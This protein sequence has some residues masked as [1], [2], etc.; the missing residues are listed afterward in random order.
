MPEVPD[1]RLDSTVASP[2]RCHASSGVCAPPH[3]QE[4]RIATRQASTRSRSSAGRTL[5]LHQRLP[6]FKVRPMVPRAARALV[7]NLRLASGEHP[8]PVRAA[9]RRPSWLPLR[10]HC[11][12]ARRSGQVT[13]VGAKQ[14]P[15]RSDCFRRKAEAGAGHQA[16]ADAPADQSYARR[17]CLCKR[18]FL[19]PARR[20]LLA[21]MRDH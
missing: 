12:H 1:V 2:S 4:A 13:A 17:R 21:A 15:R 7:P 19:D 6:V 9:L 5:S 20:A 18:A 14:P 10:R 8:Q 16:A 11:D 3:E